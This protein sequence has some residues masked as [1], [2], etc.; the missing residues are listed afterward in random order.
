M[1]AYFEQVLGGTYDNHV[2]PFLWLKGEARETITKY[3]EQIAGAD[4]RE[5]C[6]ES[7][8][9]PD[10]C[11]D[12]WWSDLWFIIDECKRLGLK[13][14]LLDDAHFPTGYANGALEGEG[15][16]PALKK[17]VLKHRTITVVGPQPSTTIKLG[18][19]MDPTERFMGA[20]AFDAAGAPLD[21]ALVVE[22]DDESIPARLRFD[23]P[24]GVTTIELYVTSQKI[25]FR[26]EYI[27]MV[28]A[29]SCRMLIDA[30][31]EPTFE[32]LGDEFGKTI[33]GFFTDEPGFMNEKGTTLDDASTSS[34]IGRG[35]LALPWSDELARRLRDTLGEGWLTEL[36]GLWTRETDGARARH[37]YMDIATQLY[38]SCFDEQ[39]GDWCRAH[40]VM[41]IGHVIEDKSCHTRLGQGAGH[42]FRAV[43][44][45]D[46]AGIDVVINQL[47]PGVDRGHYSYFHGA[48][49]MEFFTYALAKLGS[50]AARLDPKKQGR[51][52]AEVFGAFGWHEGLREMKWIA[53]HMLVRGINWFTPHAFSMA[54]F[55]DWDC[56]PH[57][58]AHGSNP[59][60]PHFGQLMRY[61]NRTAT[62]LSRGNAARPV[63]ILYHADAEWAGNAMPIERVAAELTR[64]QIDFD[65]VPAE[66]FEDEGRYEVSIADGTLAVNG[67]RYQAFVMP[68]ASFT[69]AAT[70]EAARR[71]M[72]AGVM[73]LAVDKVPS[74]LYDADGA[75]EL[76]GLTATP[77]AGVAD[78]LAAAGLQTVVTDTPQP[79][80]RALRY[81]RAGETYVMLVNEHPR[82]SIRCTVA[83]ARGERLRGTRL[84][85]LNGTEPVAF[86]GVLELEPAESCV[87]VLEANG[88][89]ESDSCADT[90]AG[91]DSALILNID[92]PWTVALSPAGSDGTFGEPQKLEGLCDLTAELFAGTCG[93]H[94]YH[95]SFELA[96]NLAD[97]A[98]DL[99]DVYETATLTL[100]GRPL[101]T[102]ICPPYRFATGPLTVGT[103]EL[104]IDVINT[105][106]HAIPD[107][108]ALTE[109]VAPSG[110]LGP[111][112]LC[113]Q[114]LPK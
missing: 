109:P 52:M 16:D 11:H 112:T 28:D 87:V 45:Q 101:G 110:V 88:E 29:A 33:L 77:L 41:H 21:L 71:M 91:A 94:R 96:D 14:W 89:V 72:A 106:D 104:T 60:W 18:N 114:N 78:V 48:W 69:G 7:R 111:V 75:A 99:G 113:G 95:T 35:D 20:A 27:N 19:L 47:V 90:S 98:I 97:T 54:P 15:V 5:V 8:T 100:D 73:V 17:T 58:Y 26:D 40:G 56:P 13:I 23:A 80:L 34:F 31:Y 82:E 63:A 24:A 61:M 46:M 55:P 76:D 103:H 4:I 67:C 53:D 12:G 25:G 93:T 107:I 86:D 79:W 30:V 102:R 3:L 42:Y 32:H 66:A 37:V 83:L 70:A 74:A 10:F 2:L 49:N 85:L 108:F 22:H 1:A 39:I 84:D 68:G 36:H 92:G 105:L 64:A 81:E 38:R 65:F 9:H 44:G 6:L 50:S 59:Q 57:F 43:A 51:C 62:L